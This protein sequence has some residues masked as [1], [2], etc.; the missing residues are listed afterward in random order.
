MLKPLLSLLIALLAPLGLL[1]QSTSQRYTDYIEQFAPVAVAE[2]QKHGIPASITL[3]QGLLE[4]AAGRSTLASKGNNHF[5]IKCHNTW[6]GDTMLRSDDAPNECFRVYESAD[7]SYAD[8]SRFLK[9]RRYRPLFDLDPLD[10]QAWARTLRECGYA[11]DPQYATRLISIIE[12]Y[13]L[14]QYDTSPELAE[15]PM[16]LFIINQMQK[17][18]R[19]RQYRGL[20][21]VIAAPGDTYRSIAKEFGIDPQKLTTYNDGNGPDLEIK[22]WEEVYFQSKLTE[23]PTGIKYVT[24]GQDESAHSIAQRYAVTLDHIQKLNPGFKDEPGTKLR[25]R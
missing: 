5:G 21:Y 6:T 12:Q 9:G 18:H 23:P 17:G 11:T 20:H 24:I 16:A 7:E 1:A 4:S 22:A 2:M 14:Y 3:A 13:S 25:L 15:D 19:V 8:H 10:Y